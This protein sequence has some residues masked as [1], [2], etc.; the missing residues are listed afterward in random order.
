M[1]ACSTS[2]FLFIMSSSIFGMPISGTHTVIG[3]LMGGGIAAVGFE[4][5]NWEKLGIIVIS[6]F[7]APA[8]SIIL[9]LVWIIAV[10]ILT[11]DHSLIPF[12]SRLM[13]Q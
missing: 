12:T 11:L 8:V 6:W 9:A 1:L 7:V 10:V 5:I 4:N 2:A 13:W 3:S